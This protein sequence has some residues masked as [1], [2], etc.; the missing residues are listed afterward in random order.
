MILYTPQDPQ[1][2][3]DK[4]AELWLEHVHVLSKGDSCKENSKMPGFLKT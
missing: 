4:G 3:L 1:E 2:C